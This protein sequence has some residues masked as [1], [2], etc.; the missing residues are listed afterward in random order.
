MGIGRFPLYI[1]GEETMVNMDQLLEFR[2][3]VFNR[4]SAGIEK[5][6]D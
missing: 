3:I 2:S 6:F 1:E 4:H 5:V